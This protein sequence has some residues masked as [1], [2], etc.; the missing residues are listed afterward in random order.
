M[1]KRFV[2]GLFCGILLV[3]TLA[4]VNVLANPSTNAVSNQDQVLPLHVS[5]K[6]GGGRDEIGVLERYVPGELIV[7][8]RK[9]AS[10]EEVNGLRVAGQNFTSSL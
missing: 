10:L 2:A 9:G 5:E 6:V 7:K 4:F 3:A 8:F 1:N